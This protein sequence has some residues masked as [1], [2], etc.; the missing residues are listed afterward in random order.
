MSHKAKNKTIGR[1]LA[2]FNQKLFEQACACFCTKKTIC[3]VLECNPNTLTAW[4]YRTYGTD[5]AHARDKFKS[6]TKLSLRQKQYQ[7]AMSGDTNMLKWLGKQE[8][9]QAEVTTSN[10]VEVEDLKAISQMLEISDEELNKFTAQSEIIYNGKGVEKD[11][12]IN[13]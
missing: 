10:N 2:E 11:A 8:L 9:G 5:F 3:D 6:R 13:D 12:E 4:C 7:V 1:P